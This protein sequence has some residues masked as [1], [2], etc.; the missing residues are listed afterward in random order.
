MRESINKPNFEIVVL[1]PSYQ[2]ARKL[3][4]SVVK[5]F[6][7]IPNLVQSAT[8]QFLEIELFNDSVIQFCSAESGDNLRGKTANLLII[9]E[10]AFVDLEVAEEC[11]NF[12]NTTKGDVI[13]CSTPTFEDDNNLFYKYYKQAIENTDDVYL[14]DYCRYDT[15]VMLSKKRMELYKKTLPLNVYM[16]EIEG[17]FLTTKSALWDIS[18]VLNNQVFGDSITYAGIDFA[19]GTNGDETAIALFNSKKQMF[20]LFHF[21]DKDSIETVKFIT[22]IFKQYNVTKAVIETNSIGQVYRDMLKKE[23]RTNRIQTQLIEFNTNNTSKRKIIE[24]LQVEIA[25]ETCSLLPDHQLKV[26]FAKFQMK[27][28]PS[29]LITYGNERD[30]DHDDIVIAT[31]LGLSAFSQGGYA[32][33]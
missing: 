27:K 9:D 30:S 24:N 18:N 22:N 10:G 23:I 31:A 3:Y 2:N 15:T 4:K 7:K 32:V 33:R 29:G 1:S 17:E 6:K 25:N 21:R 8:T 12:L 28:T 13:I 26:E 20:R 16:N 14:I 19:T 5:Y 11:F